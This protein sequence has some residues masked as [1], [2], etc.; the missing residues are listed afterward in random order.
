MAK[1]CLKPNLSPQQRDLSW[2]RMVGPKIL[3]DL[4]AIL[5]TASIML[6]NGQQRC[7]TV[8]HSWLVVW[9]QL[10]ADNNK[11]ERA[12]LRNAQLTAICDSSV[13]V[14]L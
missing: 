3:R 1:V 8:V 2:I 13:T 7:N 14:H 4:K 10:H 12:L 9:H 11:P 6:L 5:S